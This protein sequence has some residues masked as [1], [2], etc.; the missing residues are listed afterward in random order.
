MGCLLLLSLCD[1]P[2]VSAGWDRVADRGRSYG[3]GCGLSL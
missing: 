3:A 2:G 1:V